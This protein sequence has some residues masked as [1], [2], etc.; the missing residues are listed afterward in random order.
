MF[1]LQTDEDEVNPFPLYHLHVQLICV[2]HSHS[3]ATFC[4]SAG[5]TVVFDEVTL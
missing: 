5:S 3:Q 2:S 1:S 4:S